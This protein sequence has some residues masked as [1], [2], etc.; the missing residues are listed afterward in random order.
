MIESIPVPSNIKTRLD[1]LMKP[2][3]S[4]GDVIARVLDSLEDDDYIDAETEEE[5][6]KGL[7]EF[8]AGIF[9]T[10]EEMAKKLEL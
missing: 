6:K 8:E 10:E 4:Y 3:E 9:L 7:K 1:Q 2:G 5:I